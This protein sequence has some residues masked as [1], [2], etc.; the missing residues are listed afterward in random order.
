[1]NF[2]RAALGGDDRALAVQRVPQ[3]IDHAAQNRLAY[4]H[5]QQPPGAPHFLP[6][7]NRKV[8]AENDHPHRILFQVHGQS[9]NLAGK[10]DHFSGHDAGKSVNLR[11]P[12]T[13]LEDSSHL[14]NVDTGLV[15]LNLLPENGSDLVGFESHGH[16]C[17]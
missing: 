15:L 5:A 11:D 14:A 8:I 4:R 10:L 13:D 1:M 9:K 17:Q 6:F 7:V 12:V 16:S 3:R 2:D